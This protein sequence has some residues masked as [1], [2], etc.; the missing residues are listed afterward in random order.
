MLRNVALIAC[1]VLCACGQSPVAETAS[2]TNGKLVL[3]IVPI[4]G[5]ADVKGQRYRLLVCK[6]LDSYEEKDFADKE[7]CRSALLTEDSKEVDLVGK[8]LDDAESA[9]LHTK[10]APAARVLGRSPLSEISLN[11]MHGIGTQVSLGTVA[12]II[13][14]AAAVDLL[15][16]IVSVPTSISIALIT[17]SVA[18]LVASRI[19]V[20]TSIKYREN[21]G[22]TAGR[23]YPIPVGHVGIFSSPL[24]SRTYNITHQRWQDIFS[25]FSDKIRLEYYSDLRAILVAVARF[26]K[27]NIN[28][29]ALKL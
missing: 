2:V 7:V 13:V 5:S 8:K 12:K 21:I 9:R 15:A 17:I 23:N 26:Y 28:E 16:E 3:G 29:D 18:W 25:K 27:L 1:W 10:F 11:S 24:Y 4:A 19:Y 6:Q 22:D 20:N 14:V